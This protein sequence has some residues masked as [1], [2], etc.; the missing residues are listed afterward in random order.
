MRLG[1]SQPHK[2][3]DPLPKSADSRTG[4][5]PAGSTNPQETARAGQG[6]P[7]ISWP[8]APFDAKGRSYDLWG[9]TDLFSGARQ[10][11]IAHHGPPMGVEIGSPTHFQS[12]RNQLTGA[13]NQAQIAHLTYPQDKDLL[14]SFRHAKMAEETFIKDNRHNIQR[15]IKAGHKDE[16]VAPR[17]FRPPS[18]ALD[19]A[20]HSPSIPQFHHPRPLHRDTLVRLDDMVN[21]AATAFVNRPG[22]GT[23]KGYKE[24]LQARTVYEKAH[25]G[26][27]EREMRSGAWAQAPVGWNHHDYRELKMQDRNTVVESNPVVG[28]RVYELGV[29]P[30]R[31]EAG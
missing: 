29:P 24:A 3:P 27:I 17:D 22:K 8:S 7:A 10:D 2:R 6:N 18:L 9:T 19:G 12:R 16:Y 28:N 20:P 26:E 25:K 14:K 4:A 13:A 23:E 5:Q 1:P 31:T 21:K 30:S 15:E 11:P